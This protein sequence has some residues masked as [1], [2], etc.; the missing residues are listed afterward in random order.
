MEFCCWIISFCTLSK[1]NN[2]KFVGLEV[3]KGK[4]IYEFYPELLV[5]KLQQ[6]MIFFF[7][8]TKKPYIISNK[9]FRQGRE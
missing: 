7:G 5:F 6:S 1:E 2:T 3:C 8:T 4:A 9:A